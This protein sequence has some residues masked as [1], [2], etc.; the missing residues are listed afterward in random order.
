[1]TTYKIDENLFLVSKLVRSPKYKAVTAPVAVNHIAVVDCSGSMCGHS[2]RI[3]EQLKA[4]LPQLLKDGDTFSLI[5]FSGRGEHGMVIDHATVE[6]LKDIQKIGAALDKYIRPQGMTGFKEPMQSVEYALSSIRGGK[7]PYALLFMSDGCENQWPRNE[8]IKVCEALNGKLAS[9]VFV[10]YGNYA[11][12]PLLAAMAEKAGGTTMFAQD[13]SSY[14]PIFEKV[15]Q[16]KISGEPRMPV[17]VHEDVLGGF[18]FGLDEANKELVVYDASKGEALVSPDMKHMYYLSPTAPKGE[19]VEKL[20][21]KNTKVADGVYAALSLFATRMQPN[22]IYPLLKASGDVMFIEQFTNCFGKQAYTDF[23]ELAKE[24]VFDNDRRLE[25][26]WNPDLVPKEDAFT[27]LDLLNLLES[28]EDTRLLLDHPDFEYSRISRKRVNKDDT[29][30]LEFTET[31]NENGYAI[32][33]LTWNENSPNVSVQVTKHGYV[34]LVSRSNEVPEGIKKQHPD[35]R[36]PTKIFRNYSIIA[37]GIVNVTMLPVRVNDAM[38]TAFSENKVSYT[39]DKHNADGTKDVVVQLHALPIINRKMTKTVSM[40]ESI[41]LEFKLTEARAR[42][43][44][45]KAAAEG[46]TSI[47]IA[48]F[49]M[50]YGDKEAEWLKEQGITEYSGFSP[51]MVQAESTDVI[52]GRELNMKLKGYST[53]PPVAKVKEKAGGKLNGPETLMAKALL[54]VEEFT[55]NN[56]NKLHKDWLTSQE[57]LAIAQTR[58]LLYQTSQQKFSILVGQVWFKEFKSLDETSMTVKIGETEVT[59]TA[60]LREVDIKV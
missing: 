50:K 5:W 52:R 22:I 3:R 49:A 4:R 58:S 40:E 53:L 59:G 24:A 15:M 21:Q 7:N 47:K 17:K 23:M 30:A 35:F 41:K 48:G 19:K 26:G 31:P 54:E 44:V 8:V 36:F 27:V 56:P 38:L 10:E 57:K 9:A 25:D 37:H 46:F 33:S 39:I 16:A 32:N 42:Q 20:T 12:R 14:E 60:E 11:D 2:D 55:K 28:S 13:F 34:D 45:F 43:K 29:N 6:T 18:V 51:K 1:M